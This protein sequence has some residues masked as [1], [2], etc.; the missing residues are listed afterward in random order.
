MA[1]PLEATEQE[2]LAVVT[3]DL[4]R[5]EVITAAIETARQ[6]LQPAGAVREAE[7]ERLAAELRQVEIELRR[8]TEA[9]GAGGHGPT[10]VQAIQA[11]EVQ[12]THLQAELQALDQL[13]QVASIDRARIERDLGS[14]LDEW[15]GL[16]QKHVQQ[17]R[18][19]LRKL[20]EGRL[21]FT[22]NEDAHGP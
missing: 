1:M 11:R 3:R 5:P 17:A 20:L 6:R 10:L 22:A 18:Q 2:V 15:R 9:V 21:K 16:L 19:I 8:L 7:Q 12:R 13:A 4:L 14:I